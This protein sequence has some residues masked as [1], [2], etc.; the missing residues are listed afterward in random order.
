MAPCLNAL[1]TA[2]H[3]ILPKGP[4]CGDEFSPF[5]IQ[6]VEDSGVSTCNPS[7]AVR[8]QG[9][10]VAVSRPKRVPTTPDPRPSATPATESESGAEDPLVIIPSA[11]FSLPPPPSSW[12]FCSGP[13][14]STIPRWMLL[15]T[16]FARL[17]RLVCLDSL[18]AHRALATN[19][20]QCRGSRTLPVMLLCRFSLHWRLTRASPP[21]SSAMLAARTTAL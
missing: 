2:D 21:I 8:L 19:I 1:D 5:P 20:D 4:V 14:P 10:S 18:Q 7:A 17:K 16:R 6:A 11:A 13:A 12:P 9:L 3:A 15:H